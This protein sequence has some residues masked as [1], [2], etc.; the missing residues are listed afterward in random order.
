MVKGFANFLV[1]SP[2]RWGQ[3][4]IGMT[5]PPYFVAINIALPALCI[6]A[7]GGG[8][9]AASEGGGGGALVGGCGW[10]GGWVA[11]WPGV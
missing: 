2:R 9:G 6:H 8:G 3:A 4:A 5:S 11:G 10:P 1:S 7:G